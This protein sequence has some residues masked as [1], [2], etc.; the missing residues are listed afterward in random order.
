LCGA[1]AAI[2]D[3]LSLSPHGLGM[4]DGFD[5]FEIESFPHWRKT[6]PV[7]GEGDI[8]EGEKKNESCVVYFRVHE[9]LSRAQERDDWKKKKTL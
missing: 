5:D 6:Q 3:V 1:F 9:H 4:C 2:N 8:C 7:V